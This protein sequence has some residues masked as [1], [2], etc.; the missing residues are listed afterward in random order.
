MAS[1]WPAPARSCPHR[2]AV[3]QAAAPPIIVRCGPMD[4]RDGG[5]RTG[6]LV[7]CLSLLAYGY[8]VYRGPHH[9]PDSRLAL[10]YSLVERGAL[11]IDPYAGATLDRAFARGHYFTDKAP[12][13]SFLLAP[14]YAGLRL[15]LGSRLAEIEGADGGAGG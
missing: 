4:E 3:A 8:F 15:A 12:G 7:L 10:T 14:L 11:D 13:L 5:R 9:N 6:L 2:S 1:S